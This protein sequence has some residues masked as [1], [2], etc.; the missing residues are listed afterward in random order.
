M[1][2]SKWLVGSLVITTLALACSSSN[3]GGGSGTCANVDGSWNLSGACPDNACTISQNGCSITVNCSPSGDVYTGSVTDTGISF[4]D[5][6]GNCSGSVNGKTSSGSC[7]GCMTLS[8]A[9]RPP[10]SVSQT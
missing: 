5:T 8:S 1:R 7:D 3:S 10:H 4:G 6:S 2:L 9:P